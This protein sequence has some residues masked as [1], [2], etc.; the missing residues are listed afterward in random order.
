MA[1]SCSFDLKVC[2]QEDAVLEFIRAL[3]GDSQEGGFSWVGQVYSFESEK[4]MT[5]KNENHPGMV[6][7]GGVGSCPYSLKYAMRDGDGYEPLEVI[8]KRLGLVVEVFSSEPDEGFQEHLLVNQGEVLIDEC[9][10]YEEHFVEG[11]DEDAVA[12][13]A[14]D[15]GLTYEELMEQVNC[16]GEFCVGGIE[17]YAEFRNLF[18]CFEEKAQSLDEKIQDAKD[19]KGPNEPSREGKKDF[20]RERD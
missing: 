13:L 17:D 15:K 18:T 3:V 9:V 7:M 11:M 19:W 1:N 6:T 12:A 4:W 5:E 2:G 8:S 10:D 16:N 14:E 20:D